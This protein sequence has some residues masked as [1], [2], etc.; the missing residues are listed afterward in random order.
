VAACQRLR[1]HRVDR[2]QLRL[3]QREALEQKSKDSLRKKVTFAWHPDDVT[4]VFS[5][6]FR[7]GEDHFKYIDLPLSNYGSSSYDAIL[8]GS[9]TVGFSMFGGYSYNERSMLSLGVVDPDINVGDYA[10]GWRQTGR[11]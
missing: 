4:K 3:E 5:S 11:V 8:K 6:L 9:K 1:G 10:A 2:R 7:P